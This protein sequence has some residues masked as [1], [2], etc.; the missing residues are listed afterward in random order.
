MA[1]DLILETAT[2]LLKDD[3]GQRSVSRA[4]KKIWLY[5]VVLIVVG[6]VLICLLGS[7][8]GYLDAPGGTRHVLALAAGLFCIATVTAGVLLLISLLIQKLGSTLGRVTGNT[9][10]HPD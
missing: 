2:W 7:L 8:S 3:G 1:L 10:V 9:N 6:A 5:A 4:V